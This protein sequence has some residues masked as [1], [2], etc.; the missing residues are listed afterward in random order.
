MTVDHGATACK[1]PDVAE[2]VETMWARFGAKF[3]SPAA[4]ERSMKSMR[5]RCWVESERRDRIG[6]LVDS[7]GGRLPPSRHYFMKSGR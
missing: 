1:T 7:F 6:P 3:G 5:R 4:H 2:T